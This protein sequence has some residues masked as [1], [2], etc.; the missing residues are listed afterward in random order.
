[1]KHI[2]FNLTESLQ[3]QVYLC[4]VLIQKARLLKIIKKNKKIK[5]LWP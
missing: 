4:K 3:L 1:M 2:I 5:A